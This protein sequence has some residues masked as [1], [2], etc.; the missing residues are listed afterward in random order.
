MEKEQAESNNIS[1]LGIEKNGE[2]TVR[3]SALP[4]EG[5]N[6]PRPGSGVSPLVDQ[7]VALSFCCFR[8]ATLFFSSISPS[9]NA[10][11]T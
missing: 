3:I 5:V 9:L 2:H 10:A 11:L 8:V 4:R 1:Q 7:S 6:T